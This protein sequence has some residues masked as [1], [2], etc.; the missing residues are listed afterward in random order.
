MKYIFIIQLTLEQ[1]GLERCGSAYMQILFNKCTVSPPYAQVSHL[2]SQPTAARTGT[3]DVQRQ[4]YTL[5]YA[6]LYRGLE[7]PPIFVPEGGAGTSP[8]GY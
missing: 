4:L 5:L 7:H 3:H 6:I 2:Q 1:H 8:H